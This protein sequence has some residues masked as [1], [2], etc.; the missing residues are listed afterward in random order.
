MVKDREAWLAA[1]REVAESQLIA[2]TTTRLPESYKFIQRP[3][4]DSECLKD[5]LFSQGYILEN[6]STMGMMGRVTTQQHGSYEEPMF[7]QVQLE[8]QLGHILSMTSSNNG[9]KKS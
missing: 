9:V 8:G 7:A 3:E 2:A 5:T 4:W 1:V 6:G